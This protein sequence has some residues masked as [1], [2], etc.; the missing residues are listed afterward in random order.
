MCIGDTVK[1]ICKA[2]NSKVVVWKEVHGFTAVVTPNHSTTSYVTNSGDIITIRRLKVANHMA[3]STAE[4]LRAA[5][6]LNGTTLMCFTTYGNTDG[7]NLMLT[8]MIS[9]T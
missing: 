6:S 5:N 9:G 8:V 4:I 1:L 7:P 3:V 2:R